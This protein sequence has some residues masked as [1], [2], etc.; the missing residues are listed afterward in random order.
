MTEREFHEKVKKE[1][2]K[3]QDKWDD[4][5]AV[6]DFYDFVNDAFNRYSYGLNGG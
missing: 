5:K 6:E 2:D 1:L 4:K 3:T